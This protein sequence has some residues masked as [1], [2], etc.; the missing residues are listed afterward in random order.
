MKGVRGM[1]VNTLV[2]R[3]ISGIEKDRLEIRPGLS[4]VLNFMSRRVPQFMV[5]RIGGLVD[6]NA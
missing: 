2:K 4:N 3:A 1:D 5:N 6:S